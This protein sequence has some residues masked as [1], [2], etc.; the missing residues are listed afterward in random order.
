M[1]ATKAADLIASD[2]NDGLLDLKTAPA[3]KPATKPFIVLPPY[4]RQD[5]DI[6]RCNGL[7]GLNRLKELQGLRLNGLEGVVGSMSVTTMAMTPA[8][9]WQQ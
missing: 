9:C 1:E 5:L 4:E 6:N 7:D 2:N 3:A 8:Q